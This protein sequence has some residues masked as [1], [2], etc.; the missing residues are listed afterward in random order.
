MGQKYKYIYTGKSTT[1]AAEIIKNQPAKPDALFVPDLKKAEKLT[2]LLEDV[3]I[4]TGEKQDKISY[5]ECNM[6]QAFKEAVNIITEE[7]L[8]CE[9]KIGR[10]VCDF[11][12]C[13][14][15]C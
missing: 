1:D 4:V 10:I 12:V 6:K 13:E 3:L 11:S 7:I 5:V 9:Q 15:S 2:G 14:K 8:N